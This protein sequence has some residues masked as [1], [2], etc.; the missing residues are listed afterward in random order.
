MVKGKE[1]AVLKVLTRAA[2]LHKVDLP[3]AS[4]DKLRMEINNMVSLRL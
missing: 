3:S 1:K 2:A 4:V